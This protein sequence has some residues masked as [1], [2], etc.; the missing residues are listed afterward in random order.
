LQ[1]SYCLSCPVRGLRRKRKDRLR[2]RRRQYAEAAEAP[3]T[4]ATP[5]PTEESS[6]YHFAAGK[7]A[8]DANGFAAEKYDYELPLTTTDELLQYWTTIYTPEYLT[9]DYNDSPF[10]LLVE[11]QTG[12]NVEYLMIDGATRAE[13]FSVLLAS[14]E[15]PD[16]M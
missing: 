6:P 16:I 11:E 2:D 13:N 12:V 9:T 4:E 14:D 10:P 3:E 8:K 5:A 7:F 1:S 15:L